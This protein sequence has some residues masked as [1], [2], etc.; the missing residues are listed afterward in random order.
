MLKCFDLDPETSIYHCK[1]CKYEFREVDADETSDQVNLAEIPSESSSP[2]PR[3]PPP[4]KQTTRPGQPSLI[5]KQPDGCTSNLNRHLKNCHAPNEYLTLI[6][7]YA[8]REKS[9]VVSKFMN[10]QRTMSDVDWG[11]FLALSNTPPHRIGEGKFDLLFKR[12]MGL[13]NVP[14][15]KTLTN[16]IRRC[17]DKLRMFLRDKINEEAD[18]GYSVALDGWT[19]RQQHH[20][21]G[22]TIHYM[23]EHFH[24]RKI[25]WD[26]IRCTGETAQLVTCLGAS[27]KDLK[28]PL[29]SITTDSGANMVA[30]ANAFKGTRPILGTPLEPRPTPHLPLEH[31]RYSLYTSNSIDVHSIVFSWRLMQHGVAMV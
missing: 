18:A 28:V 9:S 19:N 5:K 22:V 2:S 15:Q 25:T 6:Y 23:T 14:C 30:L 24:R 3:S 26:L 21:L 13:K 27:L 12:K 31:I 1:L 17:S 20:F 10:Y 4:S 16:Y 11:L 8:M 7:N 29:V